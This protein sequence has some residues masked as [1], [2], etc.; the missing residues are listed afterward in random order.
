MRTS[1]ENSRFPDPDGHRSASAIDHT[2]AECLRE[3]ARQNREMVERVCREHPDLADRVRAGIRQAGVAGFAVTH[4]TTARPDPGPDRTGSAPSDPPR[5]FAPVGHYQPLEE[6]GRG[7]Q[8]TVYLAEDLRLGRR[9]AL[10][11]FQKSGTADGRQLDRFRRE[12]EIASRLDHPNICPVYDAATVDG[13]S[14]IAM[15]YVEGVTLAALITRARSSAGNGDHG[16]GSSCIDVATGVASENEASDAS[17]SNQ[18]GRSPSARDRALEVVGMFEQVALALHAAHEAGIVH[19]DLKPGNIMLTGD[20]QPVLMDFGIAR[21]VNRETAGLTVTGE[22]PGTPAYMSPEQ[23]S[24]K[25]VPLDRRTDVYSLAA[26]L[27]ECV[28]LH[29]PV[30]EPT[31]DATY[32]AILHRDPPDPRRVNANLPTDLKVILDKALEKRRE[33]RYPSAFELAEDLRRLRAHEPIAA[34]PIGSAGRLLRWARRRPA[35]AALLLTLL[36]GLPLISGLGTYVLAK[37]PEV[38]AAWNQEFLAEVEMHIEQGFTELMRG[39]DRQAIKAFDAALALK[40]D[41]LEA[42]AGG[43]LARTRGESPQGALAFLDGQGEA[44]R[45]ERAFSRMRARV[46]ALLGRKRE[47]DA[48]LADLPEP[49]H[50]VGLFVAGMMELDPVDP[51]SGPTSNARRA[52]NRFLKTVLAADNP[53]AAYHFQLANAAG[54]AGDETVARA[55]ATALTTLWPDAYRAWEFAGN[56]LHHTHQEGALAVYRRALEMNPDSAVAHNNLALCLNDRRQFDE[57]IAVYSQALELRPDYAAAYS[58]LGLA[59]GG[60]NRVDEAID[61]FEKAV[62][63]AP[64]AYRYH[65]NLARALHRQQKLDRCVAELET[66]LALKE[67]VPEAHAM[68][69]MVHIARGD[70]SRALE[71]FLRYVT[72]RPGDAVVRTSAAALLIDHAGQPDRAVEHLLEAIRLDPKLSIAHYNLGHAYLNLGDFSRA[73]Q[74]FSRSERLGSVSTNVRLY[75]KRNVGECARMQELAPRLD[76]VLGGEATLESALER[77]LL[78]K[79]ALFRRRFGAATTLFTAAFAQNPR[80]AVTADPNH[81][82]GLAYRFT[83]ACAAAQAGV[84]QGKDAINSSAE[85][86]AAWRRQAL[87]W[88]G[89]NAA[90]IER[91]LGHAKTAVEK[92]PWRN[93]LHFWKNSWYLSGI[94][95]RD[96]LARLP[97]EE[98]PRFEALWK[99]VD[100]LLKETE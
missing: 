31:R 86:R 53:R 75:P 30:E 63:L 19:R 41:I 43:V 65:Y 72:L 52:R 24:S 7:G 15:R 58:G 20:G 9:V 37:L 49:D 69:S 3:S 23:L 88:L 32:Q 56:A 40:P 76:K 66:V 94:R 36:A 27:Y 22:R 8:A 61:A 91:V 81:D 70:W 78:A 39:F 21:E 64:R 77:V 4:P 1:D 26:T 50:P 34:R 13:I 54:L 89:Q 38:R 83:A 62:A 17:D 57:A 74:S 45:A 25:R 11:I 99:R 2:L 96:A 28:T 79:V 48:L 87:V 35:R 47:A 55:V 93:R 33:R 73:R 10:K 68:M 85:Q 82:V 92:Q 97:G 46:L 98:R 5:R 100:E 6:M 59:L 67:D 12:A 60:K 16:N 80:L 71:G 90:A 51:A 84:G 29:R 95:D 42:I 14:Y 18:S 44:V